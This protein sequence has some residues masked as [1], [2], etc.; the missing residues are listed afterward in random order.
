MVKLTTSDIASWLVEELSYSP[1]AAEV[2]AKDLLAAMPQI[3]EAFVQFR[4]Q[5][6]ISELEVEGYDLQ[7]LE[8]E[9][10][11]NPI[12]ALLTLDWLLKEPEVALASLDRG[13]DEVGRIRQEGDNSSG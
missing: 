4:E 6:Q 9:H 3:M 11:M 7:R 10:S 12:A 13:H 1:Y 2:V 8:Q 5:G